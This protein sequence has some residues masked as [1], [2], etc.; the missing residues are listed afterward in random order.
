MFF[1]LASIY[2]Q[3]AHGLKGKINGDTIVPFSCIFGTVDPDFGVGE[4]YCP[5]LF[6]IKLNVFYTI[7]IYFVLG[8]LEMQY[9]CT[10]PWEHGLNKDSYLREI[11]AICKFLNPSDN[12]GVGNA[13]YDLFDLS[14]MKIK[15]TTESC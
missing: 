11:H 4:W 1:L 6:Y 8:C 15:A 13:P 5:T 3:N 14:R 9:V 7:S 12:E 10:H 2:G